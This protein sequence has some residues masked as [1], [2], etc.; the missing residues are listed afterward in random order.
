MARNSYENEDAVIP[1]ENSL[2]R[3]DGGTVLSDIKPLS[4]NHYRLKLK[5]TPKDKE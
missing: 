4:W 1:K 3:L 2:T 5:T